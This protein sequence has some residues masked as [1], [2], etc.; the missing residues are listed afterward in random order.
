MGH[1]LC[2]GQPLAVQADDQVVHLTEAI[3]P[4]GHDLRRERAVP[5]PRHLHRPKPGAEPARGC[6]PTARQQATCSQGAVAKTARGEI[7]TMLPTRGQRQPRPHPRHRRTRRSHLQDLAHS[8][9][10]ALVA[11]APVCTTLPVVVSTDH[12]SAIMNRVPVQAAACA[13]STPVSLRTDQ[14]A[15]RARRVQALLAA[16]GQ[17][18]AAGVMDLL[19]A[20][21]ENY[22]ASVLHYDRRLRSHRRD[23]PG[24]GLDRPARLTP[25]EVATPGVGWWCVRV[26]RGSRRPAGGTRSLLQASTVQPNAVTWPERSAAGRR[27]R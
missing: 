16:G 7:L 5:V 8:D 2:G 19:T 22:G 21:A 10:V 12:G 17:H 6:P 4:L 9:Q 3:L 20:A 25:P 14:I 1:H 13:A 23:R 18:R 24:G 26:E 27:P 11:T 15:T